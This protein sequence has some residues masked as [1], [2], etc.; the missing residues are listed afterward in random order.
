MAKEAIKYGQGSKG[1]ANMPKGSKSKGQKAKAQLA[2]AVHKLMGS[3]KS[4][5]YYG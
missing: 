5:V 4:T 2:K 3:K 1:K